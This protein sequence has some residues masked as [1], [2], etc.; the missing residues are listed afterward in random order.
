MNE[1]FFSRLLEVKGYQIEEA[2]NGKEALTSIEEARPVLVVLD[3]FMGDMDGIEVICS[4]RSCIQST[5]ILAISGNQFIGYRMCQTARVLGAHDALTK[6]FD[7]ETFL[8]HVEALLSH[9]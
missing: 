2:C 1:G 7:A 6:P 3:I 9:P 8:C 4:I 5:K